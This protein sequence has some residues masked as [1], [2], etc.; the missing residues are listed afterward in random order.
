M[1]SRNIALAVIV[2]VTICRALF[3]LLEA[4]RAYFGVDLMSCS[5]SCVA[6][7][8][9]WL[10]LTSRKPMSDRHCKKDLLNLFRDNSLSMASLS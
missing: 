2:R 9:V 6:A 1:L 4:E 3:P 10:K 7:D 5:C 8:L